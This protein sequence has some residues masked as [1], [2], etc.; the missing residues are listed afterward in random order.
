[1]SP[2]TTNPSFSIWV[3]SVT[4]LGLSVNLKQTRK[5]KGACR[6]EATSD[7]DLMSESNTM[8]NTKKDIMSLRLDVGMIFSLHARSMQTRVRFYTIPYIRVHI[9]RWHTD[10]A[11]KRSWQHH[12]CQKETISCT[13]FLCTGLALDGKCLLFLS[14]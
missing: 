4:A 5:F 14:M 8:C 2:C 1:M 12:Q 3:W 13:R 9:W 6:V 10:N 7:N 11:R